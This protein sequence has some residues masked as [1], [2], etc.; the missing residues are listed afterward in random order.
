MAYAKIPRTDL[1]LIEQIGAGGFSSVYKA[2]WKSKVVAAKRL[3]EPDRHEIEVLSELDHPNIVN[4]FGVIDERCECFLILELCEGGSLRSYLNKH[5]GERLLQFY[6]WAKQAGKPIEYLNKMKIVHKD[7]K[8]SNYLISNGNVLKLAD[9]GLAKRTD[10]TMTATESASHGYM[11]PEL[12]TEEKLS[13]TYDIFAYMV[14]I[15]ELW[16]TQIPFEGFS[17]QNIIYKVCMNDERLPIPSDMPEALVKLMKQCWDKDRSK[18]PSIGFI[19]SV[20]SYTE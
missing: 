6:D 20:V 3:N 1:E 19:L 2:T 5:K 18:R 7:V 12:L 11:A 4:L 9:F 10:V 8:A 15:W 16:T 13:P 17:Y 14:V